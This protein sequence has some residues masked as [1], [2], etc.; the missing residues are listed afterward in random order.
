MNGSSTGSHGSNGVD[1]LMATPVIILF[2][3]TLERSC[4][5]SVD[6]AGSDGDGDEVLDRSVSTWK[7]YMLAPALA[8]SEIHFSGSVTIRWQSLKMKRQLEVGMESGGMKI[9]N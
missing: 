3:L 9:L 4:A 5:R 7:V 8:K 1:G 2:D 6:T